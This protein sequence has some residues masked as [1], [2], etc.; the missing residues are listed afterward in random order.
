VDVDKIETEQLNK[1][2][3]EDKPKSKEE[4]EQPIMDKIKTT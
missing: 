4:K 3:P 2:E 1:Q